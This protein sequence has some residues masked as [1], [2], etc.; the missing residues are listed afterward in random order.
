MDSWSS[1]NGCF[2]PIWVVR[3]TLYDF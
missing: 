3:I 1:C 2:H